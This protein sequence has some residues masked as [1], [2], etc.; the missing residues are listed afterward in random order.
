MRRALRDQHGGEVL[1][2]A[3]LWHRKGEVDIDAYRPCAR[4]R[5][6]IV[7]RPRHR[8]A[9]LLV[10]QRV[11]ILGGIKGAHIGTHLQ[12]QS[13]CCLV[14]PALRGIRVQPQI[15]HGEQQRI[16]S[17]VEH[18]HA[19]IGEFRHDFRLEYHVQAVDRRVRHARL[20]HVDVVRKA[21]D[22]VQVGH[23]VRV[24][25]IVNGLDRKHSRIEILPVRQ[26]GRVQRNIDSGFDFPPE[27]FGGCNDHI[28]AGVAG[29]KPRVHGF[30]GIVNVVGHFDSG[31][32]L[33]LRDGVVTDEIGPVID[34]KPLLLGGGGPDPGPGG[35]CHQRQ[36][37]YI[38]SAK[39]TESHGV[40]LPS[41]QRR[42]ALQAHR[43][44]DCSGADHWLISSVGLASHFWCSHRWV[45]LWRW[46]RRLSSRVHVI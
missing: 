33:E 11:Q 40:S 13:L 23:G 34:E 31:L 25:G 44:G 46:A 41:Q 38:G 7:A 21:V 18:G 28:V 22:G 8:D 3:L 20:D 27:V 14:I 26:L 42:A 1:V 37:K 45:G 15:S 43:R 17:R 5:Q 19:A 6:R 36:E 2:G 32:L 29:Q 24:P 12:K 16:R 39:S 10:R 9:D 4:L 35:E 30:L